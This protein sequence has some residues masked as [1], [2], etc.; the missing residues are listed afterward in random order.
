MKML[1]LRQLAPEFNSIAAVTG[2]FRPLTL[3]EFRGRYV[4]LLFYPADFS[5]VCP[6]ELH[7]FSDR[8]QEFRNV[9]CDIIACSTDSHYVHCAWMQ[10][11][12]KHGGLGEMDIPLLADKS[13]K[14]SKDYG[15]LDELTGLAMRGLFIIDREGMVRQI[16]IN[17]VGVGRNVDEALRLVQAFQFSDEFGEVCPVNWRP[18]SPTMKPNTS[19]KDEYFKNAQ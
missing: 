11:S 8:A 10:Q 14:I 3:T 5:F 19:G 4:V 6:T 1:N 9:G 12:R 7:A 13:M 18:G 16:T 2:G 17:D 15:V